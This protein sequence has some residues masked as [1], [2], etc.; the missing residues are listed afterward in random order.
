MRPVGWP[1]GLWANHVSAF[2]YYIIKRSPLM[3]DS[4]QVRLYGWFYLLFL[5][6]GLHD[7]EVILNACACACVIMKAPPLSLQKASHLSPKHLPPSLR[8]LPPSLSHPTQLPLACCLFK[9][10]GAGGVRPSPTPVLLFFLLSSPSSSPFASRRCWEGEGEG[11]EEMAAGACGEEDLSRSLSLSSS[12]PM[13]GPVN[14]S[15]WFIYRYPS[16]LF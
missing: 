16:N 12:W 7:S 2:A 6:M 9:H 14:R 10:E 11:G 4:C 15:I 8:H 5:W 13:L 1:H 3:T